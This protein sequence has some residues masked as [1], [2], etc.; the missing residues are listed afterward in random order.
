MEK[1]KNLVLSVNFNIAIFVLIGLRVTVVGASIGDA[2]AFLSVCSLLG[3][4]RW[5]DAQKQE[6][7]SEKLEKEL[8]EIKANMSTLV[9]KNS[10]KPPTPASPVN[11][12]ISSIKRFF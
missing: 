10:V 12:D 4:L 5:L 9:L 2:I 8:S 3:A 7:L 11:P 1:L 6:P